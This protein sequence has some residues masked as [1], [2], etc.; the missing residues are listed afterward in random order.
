[1]AGVPAFVIPLNI[2]V[3]A[4]SLAVSKTSQGLL[5]QARN[6]YP[7]DKCVTLPM[8]DSLNGGWLCLLRFQGETVTENRQKLAIINIYNSRGNR[9]YYARQKKNLW[10]LVSLIRVPGEETKMA[11]IK[12][13]KLSYDYIFFEPNSASPGTS[14]GTPPLKV[15]AVPSHGAS[16]LTNLLFGTKS[17]MFQVCDKSGVL[18][19]YQWQ[20]ESRYLVKKVPNHKSFVEHLGPHTE[21]GQRVALALKSSNSQLEQ[22]LSYD[23]YFNDSEVGLNVLIATALV[24][25]LR[26]WKGSQK[27]YKKRLARSS[28]GS[29]LTRTARNG[30]Q[31]IS[32]SGS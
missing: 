24:S 30:V 32:Y 1:M 15:T 27:L 31:I 29:T 22:S 7:S 12:L 25:M 10:E 26:Q 8:T 11:H 17:Q 20:N 18:V 13:G 19:E 28:H 3:A 21:V 9:V 2:A 4:V 6:R 14:S 5:N 16:S 23:L